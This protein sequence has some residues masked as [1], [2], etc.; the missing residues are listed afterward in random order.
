MAEAFVLEE[1]STF[2]QVYCTE[3]LPSVHNPPPRYNVNENSSNL[4][5][6]KGDLGRGSTGANKN[7]T[8]DEWSTIMI[9]LLLNL[10]ECIPYQSKFSVCLLH[11]PSLSSTY[12]SDPLI[13]CFSGNLL[14]FTGEAILLLPSK[15]KT[16]FLDMGHMGSPTS[17]PSSVQRYHPSN[18]IST[19]R[20]HFAPRSE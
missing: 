13:S 15:K 11:T 12:R 9:Y 6:F 2:T 17:F 20:F 5:L 14:I 3:K 8:H 4:S 1:V 10:D 18:L 16:I 7:L 19:L